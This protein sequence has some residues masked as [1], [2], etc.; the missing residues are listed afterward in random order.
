MVLFLWGGQRETGLAK[1]VFFLAY[2][3]IFASFGNGFRIFPLLLARRPLFSMRGSGGPLTISLALPACFC[4]RRAIPLAS[5]IFVVDADGIWCPPGPSES[6]GQHRKTLSK[7]RVGQHCPPGTEGTSTKIVDHGTPEL[8]LKAVSAVRPSP[9]LRSL[10]SA[11][12]RSFAVY[13]AVRSAHRLDR[14]VSD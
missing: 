12:L 1:R 3:H 9:L 7:H 2:A 14:A 5:A 10:R 6:T 13:A 8:K 4:T 11:L